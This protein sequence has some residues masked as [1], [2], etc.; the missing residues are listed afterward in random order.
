MKKK[1]INLFYFQAI[2]FGLFAQSYSGEFLNHKYDSII[3][4]S[5]TDTSNN[6]YSYFFKSIYDISIPRKSK[7]IGA[8][9]F[10]LK[11]RL[12]N[13]F[14]NSINDENFVPGQGLQSLFSTGLIVGNNNFELQVAPRIL[15]LNKLGQKYS[16]FPTD[17]SDRIWGWY[18]DEINRLDRPYDLMSNRVDFFLGDSYLSVKSRYLKFGISTSS[19]WIGPGYFNSLIMTNSAP[20][21]PHIFFKSNKPIKLPFFNLE[22]D[23]FSGIMRNSFFKIPVKVVDSFTNVNLNSGI[24]YDRYANS[25]SVSLQPRGFQNLYLGFS[26]M[27]YLNMSSL[28]TFRDYLPTFLA[29]RDP[30]AASTILDQKDQMVSFMFRYILPL[31]KLE[32]YG[33][34][35]R[36]DFAA[37]SRDLALNPDHTLAYI[38]GAT[39]AFS[40]QKKNY[41]VFRFEYARLQGSFSYSIF[42][43][44]QEGWYRHNQV[45]RGFTNF[46]QIVGAGIGTGSQSLNAELSFIKEKRFT[47]RLGLSYILNNNDF[48]YNAFRASN[49]KTPWS[50]FSTYYLINRDMNSQISGCFQIGVQ[51]EKNL[52]WYRQA[53]AENQFL[54]EI[55]MNNRLTPQ[56]NIS[57]AYKL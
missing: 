15:I 18:Y 48:L 23:L 11:M 30:L 1:L 26:R 44:G 29:G 56:I 51:Y 39:K 6:C 57:L 47:S 21:I 37:H 17:Y 4:K 33:E 9:P 36:N 13:N 14:L 50:A 52:F 20:G 35:G 53:K 27:F 10:D 16:H 38:I 5:L 28:K 54:P 40:I 22:F 32:F 34:I 24:V 45:T 2:Y 42:S 8:L 43:R 3:F 19:K 25:L 46:G 55:G 12:G 49:D 31:S 41:A 7:K